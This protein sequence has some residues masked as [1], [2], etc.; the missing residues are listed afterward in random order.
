MNA[1]RAFDAAARH[2]SFAQAAEELGVSDSAISKQIAL[3][4]GAIGR[5]L[6]ERTPSGVALTLEGQE[7]ANAVIP[8]FA[9]LANGFGRYARS[10]PATNVI[11]VATLASFAAL[12]LVPVLASFR[13]QHPAIDMRLRTAD[14]LVDLAAEDYQLAVRYGAGRW[15]GLVQEALTRAELVPVCQATPANRERK[16]NALLSMYPRV[17]SSLNDDWKP[18]LAS[19]GLNTASLPQPFDFEHFVVAREAALQGLAV[20]L[21]PSALIQRDL[22]MGRLCQFAEPVPTEQ[23]FFLAYRP[24]AERHP[25]FRAVRDW[26]HT[27]LVNVAP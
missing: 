7:L 15:R 10:A 18:L 6:F 9:E 4:E 13:A 16:A 17:E 23:R 20:A 27:S 8:A 19:Q 22:A 3:L 14:R 2:T 12:C 25:A 26:L 1:V 21:L 5:R 11:Y 24:D